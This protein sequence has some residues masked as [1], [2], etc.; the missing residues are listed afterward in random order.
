[1]FSYNI[2]PDFIFTSFVYGQMKFFT[3][4]LALLPVLIVSTG[5]EPI[6]L[7]PA[8]SATAA[9]GTLK[10]FVSA[11]DI[12]EGGP[13]DVDAVAVDPPIAA[14]TGAP[15]VEPV[16]ETPKKTKKGKKKSKKAKTK[17]KK[18]TTA[19]EETA[20]LTAA[21][22]VPTVFEARVVRVGSQTAVAVDIVGYDK[23]PLSTRIV[24]F[25]Y[26]KGPQRRMKLFT[27]ISFLV[28]AVLISTVMA[29]PDSEKA[30]KAETDE[31]FWSYIWPAATYGGAPSRATAA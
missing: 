1:M 18:V 23:L 14:T 24:Q 5:A 9:T 16:V 21:A 19:K 26:E 29:A 11:S 17:V 27:N 28:F 7:V 31:D 10:P 20:P 15:D 2:A 12:N 8:E 13:L 4:V 3:A 25:D 6:P 22:S 30:G